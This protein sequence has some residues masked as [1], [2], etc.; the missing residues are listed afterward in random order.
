MFAL[1][2]LKFRTKVT[3]VSVIVIIV[4]MGIV[5][6][7][8]TTP[9]TVTKIDD[10]VFV[11]GNDKGNWYY[12]SNSIYIDDKTNIIKGWVKIVYTEK[13]KQEFLNTHK[14]D[15]YKDINR[16]LSK[17]LINYQKL[18]YQ[19]NI[20]FYYSILDDIIGSNELSVKNDDFIPKSVGNKLLDKILKDYNIKKRIPPLALFHFYT[21][22][23]IICR[24][25]KVINATFHVSMKA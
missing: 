18:T 8:N 21:S 5:Y 19:T 20:V 4:S 15:K 13:G 25:F 23:V 2:K 3:L 10:W 9:I 24:P 1:N 7:R 22:N 11:I 17:V 16:S 12:K 6:I 14:D